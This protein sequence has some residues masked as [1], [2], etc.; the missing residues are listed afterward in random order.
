MC[1][2]ILRYYIQKRKKKPAR[3]S[4]SLKS[5]SLL[6]P[7]PTRAHHSGSMCH[8]EEDG[9][10]SHLLQ[11]CHWGGGGRISKS[12]PIWIHLQLTIAFWCGYHHPPSH[13]G[14]NWNPKNDS[15]LPTATPVICDGAGCTSRQYGPWTLLPGLNTV[16][17]PRCPPTAVAALLFVTMQWLSHYLYCTVR[18]ISTFSAVLYS[19]EPVTGRCSVPNQMTLVNYLRLT[20]PPLFLFP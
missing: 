7:S 2:I 10:S 15:H 9:F 3:S 1:M 20:R 19:T 14:R 11:V 13:R 6:L 12:W 5:S 4:T 18:W 16:P 8:E 17:S